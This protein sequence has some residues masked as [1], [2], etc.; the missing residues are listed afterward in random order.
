VS[1]L[2]GRVRPW[3]TLPAEVLA[4]ALSLIMVESAVSRRSFW[5]FVHV[6]LKRRVKYEL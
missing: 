4:V 2:V 3:R 6:P 1:R 5:R